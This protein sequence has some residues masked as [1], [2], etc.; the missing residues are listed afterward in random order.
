MLAQITYRTDDVFTD[1]L[2]REPVEELDGFSLWQRFQVERYLEYHGDKLVRR[3]DANSYLMLAKAMDLHDVGRGRGGT[4]A[5]LARIMALHY[6]EELLLRD[7]AVIDMRLGA[8][9]TLRLTPEAAKILRVREA[10]SGPGKE[11]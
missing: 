5:A 11:T 7:L 3:F 6:G 8:R 1:R 2:G 9:P 4:E 10:A